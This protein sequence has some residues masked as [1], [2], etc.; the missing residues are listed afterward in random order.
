MAA[1]KPAPETSSAQPFAAARAARGNHLAA[2][3]GRH[4]GAESVSTLAHEFARL[5]G[6]LHWSFS[7]GRSPIDARSV[8]GPSLARWRALTLRARTVLVPT[9]QIVEVFARKNP[10]AYTGV[11]PRS[12][13]RGP[14]DRRR[15]L[16][17][18]AWH[19]PVRRRLTARQ[20]EGRRG[21]PQNLVRPALPHAR[22]AKIGQAV[23]SPRRTRPIADPAVTPRCERAK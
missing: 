12:S 23:G 11:R 14:K 3:F 5:I 19:H 17:V 2:A 22:S 15:Q 20:R 21:L 10:A 7:A 8:D 13:M 18:P 1:S 16:I 6:P 9:P 4:A